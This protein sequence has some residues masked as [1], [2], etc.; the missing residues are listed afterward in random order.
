MN[1][2]LVIH[3]LIHTRL[4]NNFYIHRGDLE[5]AEDGLTM[6][7]MSTTSDDPEN[8]SFGAEEKL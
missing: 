1:F 8:L 2:T 7:K 6:V 5:S 3:H 4:V